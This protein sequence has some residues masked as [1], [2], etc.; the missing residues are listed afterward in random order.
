MKFTAT[1]DKSSKLIT[2]LTTAI[3]MALFSYFVYQVLK[4]GLISNELLGMLVLSIT[5]FGF[6]INWIKGYTIT[7]GAVIVIRPLKYRRIAINRKDIL[8]VKIISRHDIIPSI[9]RLG[10]GGIFGYHGYFVN[11]SLG[12][13]NWYLTN[14]DRPVL[15]TTVNNINIILS[16]DNATAFIEA[17]AN[18][19]GA[20]ENVNTELPR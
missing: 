14:R 20:K 7:K 11:S 5:Y 18:D 9:R 19:G 17:L 12:G 3:Y 1:L 13:M 16:P 4:K 15:L 8:Q 6:Y 10:F 2:S